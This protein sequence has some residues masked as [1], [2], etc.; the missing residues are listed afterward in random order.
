MDE[1]L[2]LL[3]QSFPDGVTG[4]TLLLFRVGV[5]FLFVLHGYP[6]LR[7]LQQWA[8]ALKVPT[9][10]CLLS[11]LSMFLGGMGLIVGLLTPLASGSILISMLYA[12]FRE[13]VKGDPFVAPD[14]YLLEGYY[15]GPDGQQGEPPSSEKAFMFSLMLLLIIILGPGA[16]SLDALILD[17]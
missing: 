6:K 11:A 9:P 5:G 13:I 17:R 12:I 10:L 2:A 8:D 1:L 15:Q 3:Y 7:H 16:F 4:V 14:P